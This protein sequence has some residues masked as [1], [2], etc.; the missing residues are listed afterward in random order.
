MGEP[1]SVMRCTFFGMDTSRVVSVALR[2]IG[3]AMTLLI[4]LS[5]PASAAMWMRISV[6]PATPSAGSPVN[7][8]VLTFSAMQS[9]CWDDPRITP[10]PE[11][12]WYGS[13][14]S[15]INLGLNLV[16]LNSSQRFTVPLV[17]RQG[18][19]AYWDGSFTFPFGGAW[20]LYAREAQASDNPTVPDQCTG[21]VRT[22]DVLGP[23]P[24]ASPATAGA[25]AIAQ[26]AGFPAIPVA[27]VLGVLAAAGLGVAVLLRTRR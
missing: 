5:T 15:P 11:S 24:P 12:V 22:V 9:V 7:V 2:G 16:V 17:Q 26:P 6:N 4:A 10:I 3:A 18:N 20:Q 8:T 13:G 21:S 23:A 27:I 14:P 19:R 1:F 25:P